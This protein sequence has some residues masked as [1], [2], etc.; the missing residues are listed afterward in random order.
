MATKVNAGKKGGSK[1][2]WI[3]GGL[4]V[5][6]GGIGAYFLLRK[7]KDESAGDDKPKDDDK[8]KTDK[9]ADKK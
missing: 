7:P 5:I 1:M 3:I 2:I 8:P 4:I 6:A 9:P